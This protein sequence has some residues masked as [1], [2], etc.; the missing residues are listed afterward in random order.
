MSALCGLYTAFG[1]LYL[2]VCGD[3]P[4][5]HINKQTP[6]KGATLPAHCSLNRWDYR[7]TP[8]QDYR[9]M[10]AT[11]CKFCGKRHRSLLCDPKDL[12]DV[13]PRKEEPPKER[14]KEQE[15]KTEEQSTGK[16]PGD[17][18]FTEKEREYKR[19]YREKHREEY[20]K[21]MRDYRRKRRQGQ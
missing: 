10:E 9:T 11:K 12:P 20:N 6:E 18:S 8:L 7:T 5:L 15:P 4:Y 2:S 19:R 16:Q 1:R 21:Y 17:K 3:K 14:P 13:E